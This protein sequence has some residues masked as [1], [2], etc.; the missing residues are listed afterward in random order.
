MNKIDKKF[1]ILS[2][3]LLI[4]T[5][6]ITCFLPN[7]IILTLSGGRAKSKYFLILL[8]LIPIATTYL[9]SISDMSRA[10]TKAFLVGVAFY[11]LLIIFSSL[12][13]SIPVES[14]ALF[15]L[16]TFMLLIALKIRDKDS[17]V[18]IN[19]KYVDNEVVFERLQK[20][21]FLMFLT[22]AIEMFTFSILILLAL[23]SATIYIPVILITG[24]IFALVILKLSI[25][26][27]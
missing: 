14:L 22:L 19:L 24:F 20:V 27:K 13:F 18:K 26:N 9:I 16:S 21:G 15:I 3:I 8:S 12:G 7:N 11:I 2:A 25:K 17:K 5:T 4:F 6:I 1:Y 23:L 10:I